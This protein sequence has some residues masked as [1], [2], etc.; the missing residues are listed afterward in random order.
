MSSLKESSALNER[1]RLLTIDEAA[2]EMR[3]GRSLAYVLAH[4]Y[5][6]TDGHD[7]IPILRF[8]SCIRVP[9]WALVELLT[10]GRVVR[11]ADGTPS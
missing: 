2:E 11:L 3:I 10:T 9:R 7:G 1:P 8:G 5:E 4:R 6:A